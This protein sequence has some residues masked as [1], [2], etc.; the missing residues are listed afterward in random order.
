MLTHVGWI[1]RAHIIGRTKDVDGKPIGT[2][3]S[4]PYLYTHIYE[5]CFDYGGVQEY[6]KNMI[7][8]NLY[9]QADRN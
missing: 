2:E 1:Q 9:S 4:N 8:G 5:V 3:N 7:Y 6:I